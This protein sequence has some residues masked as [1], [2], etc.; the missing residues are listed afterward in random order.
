MDPD[1]MTKMA[2]LVKNGRSAICPNGSHL[3]MWDDQ[4]FYFRHLLDF[5]RGA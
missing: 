5:L 1:D 2:A 4:A 3:C